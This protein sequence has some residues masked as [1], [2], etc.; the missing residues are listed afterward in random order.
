MKFSQSSAVYFNYSL[1]YA[2]QDLHNLGYHGIEIWG[3]RPHM[4]RNDLDNDI[5]DIVGLLKDLKMQ[6]C[7]FIPA[8]FRYPSILCS[9]NE[10]IR[11][12]SVEYIKSAMDNAVKVGSPSVSLCPGMTL[13]DENNF[14]N[15]WEHLVKSFKEIEEYNN[16]KGLFL[17]IEPAHK[18]ES[19]LVLTVNDCLMMLNELKSGMFGILLDSGHVNINNEDFNIIIPKCKDLPLHIHLN[20]NNSDFDS[21][22]IPGKGNVDFFS[23]FSALKKINYKGFAS[24]ELGATYNLNPSGACRETLKILKTLTVQ[25]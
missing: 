21:H 2:I 1:K 11:K 19:N 5:E 20:D 25:V 24:A 14:K 6:V 10:G 12:E 16:D 8:Q 18:F 17:L 9:L 15:G 13:M 23:L 7:N 3:G 4:Y 22:L